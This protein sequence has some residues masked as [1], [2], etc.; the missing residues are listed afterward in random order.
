MSLIP[1]PMDL[2]GITIQGFKYPLNRANTH[3]GESLCVSNELT[4]E[5]GRITI[6]LLYTSRKA[7]AG[8]DSDISAGALRGGLCGGPGF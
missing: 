6:C 8:G 4:A 3:F 1:A 7:G 5:A 2:S